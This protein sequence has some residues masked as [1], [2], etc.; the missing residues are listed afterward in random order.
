MTY[1][2]VLEVSENASEEVIRMAYKALCRKYH[3][4][5]YKGDEKFANEMMSLINEAYNVLSDA[6]KRTAY[7][8]FLKTQRE[9]NNEPAESNYKLPGFEWFKIYRFLILLLG[10]ERI[11]ASFISIFSDTTKEFIQEYPSLSVLAILFDF[12]I[13]G[14]CFYTGYGM[15]KLKPKAYYINLCLLVIYPLLIGLNSIYDDDAT[16]I[17][18][19]FSIISAVNIYYFQRRKFVFGIS[20]LKDFSFKKCIIPLCIMIAFSASVYAI[21]NINFTQSEPEEEQQ[22]TST[23]QIEQNFNVLAVYYGYDDWGDMVQ[24]LNST[25]G[26][27]LSTN[28]PWYSYEDIAVDYLGLDSYKD[29]KGKINPFNNSKVETFNDYQHYVM[30]CVTESE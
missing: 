27:D 22:W 2:E 11:I 15:F 4:D 8:Y 16:G 7:D 23:E 26:D 3:P 12:I 10:I 28:V 29:A 5:V 20:E 18:I 14:L 30:Y 25:Y 19:A 1:Y 9:D 24:Y 6:E 17:L 13:A 21:G